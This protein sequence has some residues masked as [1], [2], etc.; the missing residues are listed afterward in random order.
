MWIEV[1]D[2]G[3]GGGLGARGAAREMELGLDLREGEWHSARVAVEGQGVDPG[4]A[5][6][7]Q[8]EEFGDFVVGFSG[9]VVEGAAD[10][11]VVPGVFDGADE[12]E[13]GVAAGDDEG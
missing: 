11:G 2:G 9:G 6:V 5:G 12:V 1:G 13:V 3:G 7:A 10:E 4:T 8:A